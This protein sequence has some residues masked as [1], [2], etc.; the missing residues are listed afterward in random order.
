[1]ERR[2]YTVEEVASLLGLS[3]NHTYAL[4]RAGTLPFPCFRLGRRYVIPIEPFEEWLN[5]GGKGGAS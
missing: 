3:R 4:A 1:M 5:G 2:V